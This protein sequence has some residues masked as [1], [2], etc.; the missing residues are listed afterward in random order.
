MIGDRISGCGNFFAYVSTT[1]ILIYSKRPQAPK[2]LTYDVSSILSKH[3]EDHGYEYEI[4]PVKISMI[5]WEPPLIKSCTKTAI[6][7]SD[8]S[9]NLVIILELN[10][11]EPIIIEA[12]PMGVARIQW[13]QGP[14]PDS[15][16]YQ[17]CTQLAVFPNLSLDVKVY[18]LLTTCIQ[19]TLPKPFISQILFHPKK[20]NFW[21]IVVTPY[22]HKNLI[23]RSLFLDQ[24]A[25]RPVILH[26]WT[27]GTTSQL[28]SSLKLDFLPGIHAK[29]VWSSSGRW[30]LVFDAS[31]IL[32]GYLLRVYNILGIHNKPVK[33]IS[34]HTALPS[35]KFSSP[36]SYLS[37]GADLE[38]FPFWSSEEGKE[39]IYTMS[40]SE[41]FMLYYKCY[42]ISVMLT[43]KP[44][45][46]PLSSGTVWSQTVDIKGSV[47]YAKLHNIPSKAAS[48]WK[49]VAQK[50]SI[51]FLSARN[52][53]VA[54]TV[55]QMQLVILF[56]IVTS[57]TFVDVSIVDD[58]N[59]IVAFNDNIVVSGPR[60]LKVLATTEYSF[61]DIK[62]E[63]TDGFKVTAVEET[64]SGP[65]WRDIRDNITASSCK[66]LP[67]K[68]STTE[69]GTYELTDTFYDR[70]KRKL[71]VQRL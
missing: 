70:K 32:S 30:L 50:E 66:V 35:V 4:G 2:I 18:S 51:V 45:K 1:I 23:S 57:L 47:K 67:P 16:S 3:R 41:D 11:L 34:A 65:R 10:R 19:F 8:G 44:L 63:S 29:F 36:G 37:L 58:T 33:D 26:F 7:A 24:A 31:S 61:E 43:R 64:P 25:I 71:E 20:V 55:Q 6:C 42:D 52:I 27:D 39:C 69:S 38:W 62:T 46:V 22:Y 17:N 48:P 59:Y 60:A 15:G 56:T 49:V 21:S 28:L 54:L 40:V 14:E 5:E 9:L 13:I 68:A 12:D 53:V